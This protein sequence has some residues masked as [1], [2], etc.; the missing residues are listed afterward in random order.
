M[1]NLGFVY[2]AYLLCDESGPALAAVRA[3]SLPRIELQGTWPLSQ[4]ALA[5]HLGHVPRALTR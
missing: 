2:T 4:F 1:P 5:L 3:M